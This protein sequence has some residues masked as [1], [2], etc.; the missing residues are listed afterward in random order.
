MFFFFKRKKI[1]VDCFVHNQAIKDLYPIESSNKFIPDWYKSMPSTF[2]DTTPYGLTYKSPTIKHCIAFNATFKTGF[3]IPLFT[4]IHIQID[5]DDNWSFQAANRTVEIH[6]HIH[7]QV[8]KKI[9]EKYNHIKIIS[10]WLIKEKTGV[11][12]SWNQPSWNHIYELPN[13][14]ILPGVINFKYQH[15]S[16]INILLTR[17]KQ[18]IIIKAGTP[19]M[20]LIPISNDEVIIKNHVIDFHEWHSIGSSSIAAYHS[21]FVGNYMHNKKIIDER[22]KKC[23]FGFGK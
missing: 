9:H 13:Y 15:N 3:M 6:Q 19:M 11:N 18:N 2:T 21:K 23:P 16:N 10:P 4:D 8:P 7:E 20:H 5:D 22:E 17:F 1:V 14:H 12:F